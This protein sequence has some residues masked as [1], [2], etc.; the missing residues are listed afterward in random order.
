MDSKLYKEL[1]AR[2][3]DPN[4]IKLLYLKLEKEI[5]NLSK[6]SI[7]LDSIEVEILSYYIE[8]KINFISKNKIDTKKFIFN[9]IDSYESFKENYFNDKKNSILSFFITVKYIP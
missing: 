2:K 3:F 1:Y 4:L 6:S 7:I 9:F 5:S 8:F